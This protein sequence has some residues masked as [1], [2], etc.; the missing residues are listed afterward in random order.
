ER[1]K[2]DYERLVHTE[3]ATLTDSQSGIIN[4]EQVVDWL[5]DYIEEHKLNVKGIMYDPWGSQAAITMLEKFDYPL[6]EVPQNFKSMSEPLKQF[7][8]D[9]F[10]G[11][12]AHS[13]NPNLSIAVNNA[14]CRFDNNGNIILDKKINRNKI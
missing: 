3:Y 14:V 7:R 6:I 2:I 8:L 1:D 11:N 5:V 9:V 13:G 10:E 12:I 4:Y